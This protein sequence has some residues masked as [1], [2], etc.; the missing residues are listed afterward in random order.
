M[1]LVAQCSKLCQLR[2]H[3][4]FSSVE[5]DLIES[6]SFRLIRYNRPSRYN[7]HFRQVRAGLGIAQCLLE[8]PLNRRR[9]KLVNSCITSAQVIAMVLSG[10][11]V[12]TKQAEGQSVFVSNR[13]VELSLPDLQT[14][15]FR[16]NQ[17]TQV[18]IGLPNAYP[19]SADRLVVQPKVQVGTAVEMAD[20]MDPSWLTSHRPSAE[21]TGEEQLNISQEVLPPP[22]SSPA[23]QPASKRQSV[24]VDSAPPFFESMMDSAPLNPVRRRLSS[25]GSGLGHERLAFSLFDIDP[26]QPFN[27]FRIRAVLAS[28]MHLPDRAEYFWAK[29]GSVKG[30]PLGES[31]MNYQE[32]RMRMELGSKKFS[33]AFEVPFRST[34]PQV[35]ENHAG[36]GDMQLIVKTV[37]L[38]G[39]Q[40]MLTQYF[41]THFATGNA[42]AGLG[43]GHVSLEPGMLF[44]NKL[45]EN[46]WMHGE[47][48]FWFPLGAD[49]QHGGQVLKFATGFNSVWFE[50]DHNGWIPSIEIVAFSVLNG[51]ATDS[52]GTLRPIDHDAI[53]YVTPGLH[54]VTDQKGD[55]GLFE[56]GSAVSLAV[57]KERFT[58]STWNFDMRWSW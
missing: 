11:V 3:R 28:R 50:T 16:P 17:R 34:D 31:R 2:K 52:A 29:A 56:V 19:T 49:P 38:D 6:I 5:T 20:P 14:S 45:Q 12:F 33:T 30:P 46:T 23:D 22:L 37:L 27:N 44:R 13:Q 8:F 39:N 7:P 1:P 43:T 35:N 57:S 4:H 25:N 9:M 47:L 58:D 53:F 18:R 54:Y 10:F 40:W 21:L 24:V 32:G 48:K 41:G 51:M 26:A 42:A 15:E 55:F 36:L